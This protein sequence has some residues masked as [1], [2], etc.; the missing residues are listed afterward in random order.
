MGPRFP[1][2][3]AQPL[4]SSANG[5]RTR[6]WALRGPRPSPLDDSAARRLPA[7]VAD[8]QPDRPGGNRTPNPRFWR[9]VLYQLSYGPLHQGHAAT[10]RR[11]SLWL[12][13]DLRAR[14]ADGT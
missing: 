11:A 13:A 7:F 8:S 2:A 3:G 6:V 10:V 1:P 14:V 9:P 5:I 12:A 4:V